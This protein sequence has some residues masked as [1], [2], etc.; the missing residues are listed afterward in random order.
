MPAVKDILKHVSADVAGRRRK[1]N[2]KRDHAIA[3]GDPCLVVRDAA[4]R[5][6]T[7]CAVCAADILAKA[8]R[9]LTDLLA[10]FG[11]PD[12]PGQVE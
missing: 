6:T 5:Q 7:Y 12:E 11:A 3:K 4:Q 10:R 8:E 1:C 2:R 9:S